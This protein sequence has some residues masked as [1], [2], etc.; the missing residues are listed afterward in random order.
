VGL[1]KIRLFLSNLVWQLIKISIE[2][3]YSKHKFQLLKF[4]MI[5]IRLS[6]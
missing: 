2:L 5:G 6:I 1:P 4:E 3:I